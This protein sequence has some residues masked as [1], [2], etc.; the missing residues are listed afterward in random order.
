V[1]SSGGKIS[2][3]EEGQEAGIDPYLGFHLQKY[4]FQLLRHPFRT[5][6][7]FLKSP[8]GK[9]FLF[10]A[11]LNFLLGFASAGGFFASN[12]MLLS[13]G[14]QAALRPAYA[15][16]SV[17]SVALTFL[18]FFLSRRVMGRVLFL[19]SLLASSGTV[20]IFWAV[21]TTAHVSTA[22]FLALRTFLL[23]SILFL[24][25][26]F[27]NEVA[28]KFSN[29]ESK[30]Y[31]PLLVVA[32]ILGE[33]LG[34]L[35]LEFG[36]QVLET[37]NFFLVFSLLLATASLAFRFYPTDRPGHAG[38]EEGV[39]SEAR[40][41]FWRPSAQAL[42]VVIFAFWAIYSFVSSGMDLIFN[43]MALGSFGSGDALSQ[44]LGKIAFF[45]SLA[46]L[47]YQ[48]FFSESLSLGFGVTKTFSTLCLLGFS[49]LGYFLL[50]PTMRAAE[51]SQQI[52]YFFVDFAALS[53]L[54]SVVNLVPASQRGRWLAFTEGLGRPLGC[55][56]V[57]AFPVG[58]S[59]AETLGDFR[60]PLGIGILVLA[61]LPLPFTWIYRRHLRENLASHDLNLKRN[62]V[63]A[64]G[65]SSNWGAVEPLCQAMRATE[66][67]E[68]KDSI[69]L[70]IGRIVGHEDWENLPPGLPQCLL[71]LEQGLE[72]IFPKLSTSVAQGSQWML[73]LWGEPAE[74]K[75]KESRVPAGEPARQMFEGMVRPLVVA[76]ASAERPLP[77]IRASEKH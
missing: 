3:V 62:V 65:E 72:D 64:L 10:F 38:P 50:F 23:G 19:W 71:G 74:E 18:F 49:C 40:A 68:L 2:G 1:Y 47:V 5:W 8:G 48:V 7:H 45:G 77:L 55:F 69:V 66:S 28:A 54:S 33:V 57:L 42:V 56:L 21:V 14:G 73:G 32:E 36:A 20:A 26:L 58:N 12:S 37:R 51:V 60:L 4:F 29:L 46:V 70:A 34:S 22:F 39:S 41:R 13:S 31:F 61:A 52:L 24:H 67:H 16:A 76:Q 15:V 6:H 43:Q 17:F 59:M 30:R 11:G 25:L 27:W 63:E 75:S 44:Y 35:A 9:L 53:L